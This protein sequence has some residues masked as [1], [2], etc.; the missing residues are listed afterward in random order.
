MSDIIQTIQT[1]HSARAPFDPQQPIDHADLT[2][3][4]EA[5]C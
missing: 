1:R 5:A 3:Q 2:R 4:L